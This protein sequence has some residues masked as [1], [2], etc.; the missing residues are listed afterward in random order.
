M[1]YLTAARLIDGTGS[2]PIDRGALLVDG[3][4]IA[5]VGPEE[6]IPCPPGDVETIALG[7]ATL[8]PGLIDTHVHITW[9]VDP[10]HWL[11]LGVASAERLAAD[12]EIH[13]RRTI[14]AGFT[15]VRDLMGLP[16]VVLSLRDRI[17]RGAIVGSRIAAAGACITIPAGHGTQ[18]GHANV[19]LASTANEIVEAV[20]RQV[21]AGVD[22]IKIMVG[23]ASSSSEFLDSPAYS[24]EQLQAGVA[25][26]HRAGL[27][28]CAHAHTLPDAVRTAVLAGV[29]S[30]EHGAPAEDETLRIMAA[31]GTYLVPTLSVGLGLPQSGEPSDLPYAPQV[32]AWMQRLDR[33]SRDTVRR[34][35]ALGVPIALGTDAGAPKVAH[36]AN[37]RELALLV[38]CGLS[39]MEAIVTATGNAAANLGRADLGRL[40]PGR[41]ADLVAVRGDPLVNIGYLAEPERILLVMQGGRIVDDRRTGAT[42]RPTEDVSRRGS[43]SSA[44]PG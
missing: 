2:P 6:R 39:P 19:L 37:A 4:R 21:G 1:V 34:A 17:A 12:G 5:A 3:D 43:G 16:N 22:A 27:R 40:A 33:D 11:D 41:L 29:D 26:A 24:V 31:R 10:A 36:G 44:A 30:I 35:H 20:G 25:A 18:F 8:L 9:Q 15:T 13:A 42:T 32:I 7:H 38:A 14:A 28:V 23:R